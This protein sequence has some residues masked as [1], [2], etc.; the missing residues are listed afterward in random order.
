VLL[1]SVARDPVAA[2]ATTHAPAL[3][4]VARKG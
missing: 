1:A 3:A 2:T 4:L